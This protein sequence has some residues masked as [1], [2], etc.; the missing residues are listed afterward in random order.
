M[1]KRDFIKA[2][3]ASLILTS[4]P[5]I[6]HSCASV[7]K[8][9]VLILGGRGFLGPTIVNQFLAAGH[10]VTLLNR[11][12]TNPD[13]FQSLD[14]IIC[15]REK[16]NREDLKAVKPKIEEKQWDCVVDTWQKSPKAVSDFLQ[17]FKGQFKHYHYISTMSV[18]KNWN[19][20]YIDEDRPLN[21]LPAFPKSIGEEFSYSIRKTFSE[22][23]IVEHLKPSDYTIYRCNGTKSNRTPDPKD[24]NEEPYWIVKFL[25]GEEIL[26]PLVKDHHMQITD[27]E[28]LSKFI[29]LCD[30]NNTTGAFN[31]A[32]RPIKFRDFI[33]AIIAVTGEPKKMHWIPDEFLLSEGVVPYREV[34][35]WKIKPIG[36][37][38]FDAS[39]AIKAGLV[40]RPL[41]ETIRDEVKGYKRRRPNDD[42]QFGAQPNGSVIKLSPEKEKDVIK[43]WLS[44]K[45]S[46]KVKKVS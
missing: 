20:K 8:K 23:T 38:Y 32:H 10:N 46:Y 21:D 34:P 26:L 42:I 13:L 45:D 39:K 33:S 29:L 4:V 22:A 35:Y 5:S 43:K 28:S 31:V 17:E 44:I 1:N 37:Y 9:N 16:E 18:Y 24:V 25:R 12:I 14:I 40:N 7:T 41:T 27:A 19:E 36:K 30:D 6:L 2:F 3:S 15:D 11:G